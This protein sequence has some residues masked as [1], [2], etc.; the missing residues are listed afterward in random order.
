MTSSQ[1]DKFYIV[2]LGILV[3]GLFTLCMS[4][5][6]NTPSGAIEHRTPIFYLDGKFHE[7]IPEEYI[8]E[9]WGYRIQDALG[10]E[11]T[12][13]TKVD[14]QHMKMVHQ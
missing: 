7:D 14:I 9:T 3:L 13:K 2:F 8:F 6:A 11:H 4:G 12:Y 1:Q 5:C 10:K